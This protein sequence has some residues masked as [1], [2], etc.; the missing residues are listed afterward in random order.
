MA[1]RSRYP[2]NNIGAAARLD[3]TSPLLPGAATGAM[4]PLMAWA[5]GKTRAEW[6]RS[7]WLAPGGL[8][9]V[10]TGWTAL[11]A[12][13]SEFSFDLH[14]SQARLPLETASFMATLFVASLAYL[15]YSLTLSRSWLLI[16]L[17]FLVFAL[18]QLAFRVLI[19]PGDFG[20]TSQTEIYLWTAGRVLAGALMLACALGRWPARE[21]RART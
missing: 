6:S 10:L 7:S 13:S 17:A 2:G 4:I 1:P 18:N 14:W 15:R 8:L 21:R 12:S 19:L 11:S 20:V 9:V 16:G 3:S 5:R